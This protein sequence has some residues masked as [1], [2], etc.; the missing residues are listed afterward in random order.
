M[1]DDESSA[2]G[3]IEIMTM[4]TDDRSTAVSGSELFPQPIKALSGNV[5]LIAFAK[6]G[7]F[8]AIW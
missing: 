5:D 8:C 2:F 3:R 7:E 6:R 4:L 1:T